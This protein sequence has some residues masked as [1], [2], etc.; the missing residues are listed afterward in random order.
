M[1]RWSIYRLQPIELQ[2]ADPLDLM[3]EQARRT[4]SALVDSLARE[5]SHHVKVSFYKANSEAWDRFMRDRSNILR[6]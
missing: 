3:E 2:Q 5:H 1:N 4:V 6:A